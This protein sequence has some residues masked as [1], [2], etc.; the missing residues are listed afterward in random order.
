MGVIIERSG[1]QKVEINLQIQHLMKVHQTL[2][3]SYIN[4]QNIQN[5]LL[6]IILTYG[7]AS[8][9]LISHKL[10]AANSGKKRRDT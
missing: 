7:C 3:K 10:Q 4:I 5:D 2:Y 6:P 8:W 9:V 1:Y